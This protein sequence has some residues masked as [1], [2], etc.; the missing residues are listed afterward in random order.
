MCLLFTQEKI[1]DCIACTKARSLPD[2]SHLI[3]SS[4]Y[5]RIL[6]PDSI[7][8]T[9]GVAIIAKLLGC[10]RTSTR[11]GL[12]EKFLLQPTAPWKCR[13]APLHSSPTIKNL[14]FVPI[15]VSIHIEDSEEK[16]LTKMIKSAVAGTMSKPACGHRGR[17]R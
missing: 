5:A 12:F 4:N 15:N 8:P 10:S 16:L 14:P 1:T 17:Y 13:L 3:A 7:S 9:L 11:S 6:H 2:G